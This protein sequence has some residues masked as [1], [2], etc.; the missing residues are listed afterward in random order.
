MGRLE[1]LTGELGGLGVKRVENHW[2]KESHVKT[3]CCEL[4]V[5]WG[6][7]GVKSHM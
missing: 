4:K 5:F 2:L 1:V 3:A 7:G 6:G